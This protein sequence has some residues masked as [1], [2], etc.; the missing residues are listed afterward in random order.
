MDHA[1]SVWSIDSEE[2]GLNIWE[3]EIW[4]SLE[5][6]IPKPEALQVLGLLISINISKLALLECCRRFQWWWKDSFCI[7]VLEMKTRMLKLDERDM[8]VKPK[9]STVC[10]SKE[11]WHE[12]SIS[13]YTNSSLIAWIYKVSKNLDTCFK[14]GMV[15]MISSLLEMTCICLPMIHDWYFFR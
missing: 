12:D 7:V 2:P 15:K 4:H 11:V 3:R 14:F 8:L 6:V 10:S 1:V 9:P 5:R 13:R